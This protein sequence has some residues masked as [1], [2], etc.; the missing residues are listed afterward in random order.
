MGVLGVTVCEDLWID[1]PPA[2]SEAAAGACLIVN[3]SASPYHA[4][5]GLERER[6]FAQRARET[7]AYVAFCAMVGGQD[8]LVFDGHSFVLD[9]SGETIARGAQFVEDLVVCDVDI[10]NRHG[11]RARGGHADL[12]TPKPPIASRE[13]EVYEALALGLHDYVAE[14]RLFL[15]R[16]RALGW[17]RLG[18]RGLPCRRRARRASA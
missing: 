17:D 14:E 1:G 18:A 4:G 5:K 2:S 8:E 7:G 13:Q 12:N 10:E 9:P 15:G 6:L 3:A 16:A 11:P